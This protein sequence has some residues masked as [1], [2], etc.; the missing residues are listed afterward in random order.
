[1]TDYFRVTVQDLATGDEQVTEVAS[2][3]YVLTVTAPCVLARTQRHRDGT[4]QMVLWH[5][6][7]QGP[8]RE[9]RAGGEPGH[10]ARR[11]TDVEAWI[12]RHRDNCHIADGRGHDWAVLDDLLD[13]YRLHAD[14]GVPLGD[15]VAGPHEEEA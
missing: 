4:V 9:D 3:D 5:H 10:V 13:D 1:M 8:K 14:T 2:G 12:K 7:P 6:A 11:G 15:D